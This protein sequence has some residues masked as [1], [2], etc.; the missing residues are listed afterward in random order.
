MSLPEEHISDV[1][2]AWKLAADGRLNDAIELL[3]NCV[4]IEKNDRI[5]GALA[6]LYYRMHQV[7]P[8]ELNA[9]NCLQI[10]PRNQLALCTLGELSV[11][12][13]QREEAL[14]YFQEAYRANSNNP[15]IARRLATLLTYCNQPQ[16]AITVL[17][18][19]R[20]R[21][22]AD[23]GIL[24]LL[25]FAYMMLGDEKRLNSVRKLLDELKGS[26]QETSDL[27]AQNLRHLPVET[28]LIQIKAI[29][30]IP[31]FLANPRIREA[32]AE[33]M[34]KDKKYGEAIEHLDIAIAGNP[35][36]DRLRLRQALCLVRT[37]R[38]T[39]AL[40]VLESIKHLEESMQYRTIYYEAL[41]ETGRGDEALRRLVADLERNP[42]YKPLRMLLTSLRRRG[43]RL[44]SGIAGEEK[45]NSSPDT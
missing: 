38:T 6:H 32:I 24:D 5:L 34:M 35:K 28:A 8:A 44:P 39:E 33:V 18:S 37:S 16:E 22:P 9:R 42:R 3:E 45:A 21:H 19:I 10:N 29:L 12:R 17:E 2:Q 4:S 27:L 11:R 25:A 26:S 30:R 13:D 36:S 15:Y 1:E 7:R 20:E 43:I 23:R 40:Q 14:S 31:S 41:A